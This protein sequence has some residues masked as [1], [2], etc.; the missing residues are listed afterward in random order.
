M[1]SRREAEKWISER[2]VA[3]NGKVVTELGTKVN[4]DSDSISIDGKLVKT[5]VPPKVYWL[6]NKPD[7]ANV[8]LDS[9]RWR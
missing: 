5:K 8:T 7:K 3:V 2:R 4:P 1:G 9:Q 6:L